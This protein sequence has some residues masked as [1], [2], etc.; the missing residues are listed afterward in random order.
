MSEEKTKQLRVTLKGETTFKF[1]E[2]KGRLKA[3]DND[4]AV[5]KIIDELHKILRDGDKDDKN[6]FSI[7]K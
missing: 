5:N 7:N 2:L 6:R 4:E 1:T 3:N